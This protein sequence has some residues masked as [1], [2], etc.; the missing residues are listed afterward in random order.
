MIVTGFL[1]NPVK[2]VSEVFEDFS[3]RFEHHR[4]PACQQMGCRV[5]CRS[6]NSARSGFNR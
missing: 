4:R 6:R 2:F 5:A 3:D 1:I